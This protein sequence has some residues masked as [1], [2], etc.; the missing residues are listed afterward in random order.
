MLVFTTRLRGK[1]GKDVLKNALHG[2]ST[3]DHAQASIAKIF[4]ELYFNKDGSVR[5]R[6]HVS[7]DQHCFLV[8][9]TDTFFVKEGSAQNKLTVYILQYVPLFTTFLR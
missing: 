5:G 8:S 1:Y 2:S 9:L 7:F 4:G 3:K 6:F